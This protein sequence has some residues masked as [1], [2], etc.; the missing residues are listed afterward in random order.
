M[1][2]HPKTGY[3]K[4][5]QHLYMTAYQMSVEAKQKCKQIFLMKNYECGHSPVN[6]MFIRKRQ[7][8]WC[9]VVCYFKLFLSTKYNRFYFLIFKAKLQIE[10]F[11]KKK[12]K[13]SKIVIPVLSQSNL[14]C[15][16]TNSGF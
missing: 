6:Q 15:I 13:I 3:D 14:A 8:K 10:S 5:Y 4:I 2:T 12:S 7:R 9:Y 11:V 16:W 1:Q